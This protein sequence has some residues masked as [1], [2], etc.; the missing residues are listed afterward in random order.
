MPLGVELPVRLPL[1]TALMT[2]PVG[3]LEPVWVALADVLDAMVAPGV[4]EP[5]RALF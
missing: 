1:V 4:V 2:A 3:V 5:V